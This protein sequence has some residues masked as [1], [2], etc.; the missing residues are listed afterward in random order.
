MQHGLLSKYI[1]STCNKTFLSS[2][3]YT[4]LKWLCIAKLKLSLQSPFRR[5]LQEIFTPI[6]KPFIWKLLAKIN[7]QFKGIGYLINIDRPSKGRPVGFKKSCTTTNDEQVPRKENR[8]RGG[9]SI[10]SGGA[11]RILSR[12]IPNGQKR[13]VRRNFRIGHQLFIFLTNKD[14]KS[15]FH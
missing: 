4:S 14:D 5:N 7:V 9:Y 2:H 3:D 6:P 11:L 15:F 10:L 13:G 1:G 8:S 12:P